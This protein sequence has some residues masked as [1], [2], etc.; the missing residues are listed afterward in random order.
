MSLHRL[1][2]GRP[3]SLSRTPDETWGLPSAYGTLEVRSLEVLPLRGSREAIG[4]LF[5]AF[6]TAREASHASTPRTS[7]ARSGSLLATQTALTL[8]R[9][10][11]AENSLEAPLRDSLTAMGNRRK[12]QAALEVL[13]AGDAIAVIDLD[14][15]D[16]VNETYGSAAGDRVLRTM[17]EFLRNSVRE[18]DEV[19]RFGGQEFLLV[20]PSAGDVSDQALQRIHRAWQVQKRVTSFS[21]G[22]A[23]HGEADDSQQTLVRAKVALSAAKREGRDRVVAY[24]ADLES[25][26]TQEA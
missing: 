4:A 16:E 13:K 10:R 17:A 2:R 19:F 5:V 24:R 14:R 26:I 9:L 20:L 15:F 3:R 21:A 8:E 25:E 11:A 1:V 12:A 22:V 7:T 18:P 23:I 6:D